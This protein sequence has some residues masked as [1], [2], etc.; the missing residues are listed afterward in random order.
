VVAA[1]D[2]H[3]ARCDPLLDGALVALGV[4]ELAR[5]VEHVED[6]HV[7]RRADRERAEAALVEVAAREQPFLKYVADLERGCKECGVEFRYGTD[8]L[9]QPDLLAPFDRI[10]V[11]TGAKYRYGLG[12]L[13]P[14]LLDAGWGRSALARRLFDSRAVREWFYYSARRGTAQAIHAIARPG[15]K[16]VVIGDARSAGKGKEAIAD[17]FRAALQG[18]SATQ[19]R[20]GTS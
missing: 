10:V 14:G 19:A 1:V 17:A 11:A 15:Q 5:F 4:F 20:A 16:L 3:A 9:R 6:R 12:A 13:V 8:V 18:G 7:R 2:E